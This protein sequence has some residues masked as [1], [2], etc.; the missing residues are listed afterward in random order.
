MGALRGWGI[1]ALVLGGLPTACAKDPD[2]PRCETLCAGLKACGLLPSALGIG[3]SAEAQYE[4]CRARCL[5]SV[6]DKPAIQA[7]AGTTGESPVEKVLSCLPRKTTPVWDWCSEQADCATVASCL[8]G[9]LPAAAGFADLVV[10]VGA[11]IGGGKQA[12]AVGAGGADNGCQME[13]VDAMLASNFCGNEQAIDATA[14]AHV[15]TITLLRPAGAEL[16]DG[17]DFTLTCDDALAQPFPAI[18]LSV[19]QYRLRLKITGERAASSSSMAGVVTEPF[20]AVVQS[21][22]VHLSAGRRNSIVLPVPSDLATQEQ[23]AAGSWT[24]LP[25]ETCGNGQDDD[26]DGATDC[27]DA[28]CKSNAICTTPPVAPTMPA[29]DGEAGAGP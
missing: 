20:C 9:R 28:V 18:R 22:F 3:S 23:A 27:E 26:G 8:Q 24:I 4:N 12:A 19:G 11:A 10:R 2:E 13:P 7:A 15:S 1:V 16:I 14:T 21:A 29:T 6:G 17:R 25:C 5:Q